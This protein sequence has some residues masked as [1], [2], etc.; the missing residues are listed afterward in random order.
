M[1]EKGSGIGRG[2]SPGRSESF[3]RGE[4]F[5]RSDRPSGAP[6]TRELRHL[7]KRIDR[8]D[9]RV[10]VLLARRQCTVAE[11]GKIKREFGLPVEDPRR[12]EEIMS[13]IDRCRFPEAGKRYIKEVYRAIFQCS[14]A[15]EEGL[16]TG[17]SRAG[18]R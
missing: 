3:G 4:S 10:V 1:R 6:W 5:G 7:R 13:R 16:W 2:E 12:E 9:R 11:V 14:Y 15:A 8:I 17:S 18:S